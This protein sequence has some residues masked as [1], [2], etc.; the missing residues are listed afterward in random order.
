MA[1]RMACPAQTSQ[2]LICLKHEEYMS[3]L[4]SRIAI[5]LSPALPIGTATAGITMDETKFAILGF[6]GGAV[7]NLRESPRTPGNGKIAS[8]VWFDWTAQAC[9]REFVFTPF[10]SLPVLGS[11]MTPSEGWPSMHIP[12]ITQKSVLSGSTKHLVPSSGSTIQTLP[13]VG[14]CVASVKLSSVIT[15]SNGNASKSLDRIN[16]SAC[17]SACVTGPSPPGFCLTKF[18]SSTAGL[19]AMIS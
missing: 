18:D 16:W 11:M 15:W 17:M 19:A 13:S 5:A 8:S 9:R 10:H 3:A 1:L 4:P 14:R 12:I 2:R 7:A 6:T